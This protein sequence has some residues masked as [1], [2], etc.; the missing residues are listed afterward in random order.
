MKYLKLIL[1]LS[2]LWAGLLACSKDDDGTHRLKFVV[3]GGAPDAEIRVS[4]YGFRGGPDWHTIRGRF[5]YSIASDL[6]VAGLEAR[7]DDP[8][9][10]IKVEIYVDGKL[11]AQEYGTRSVQ[12][13]QIR[14]K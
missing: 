7:C 10:W 14:L 4:Y 9:N 6:E 1:L 5:E 12:T 2:L 8:T 3:E 13:P 11:K